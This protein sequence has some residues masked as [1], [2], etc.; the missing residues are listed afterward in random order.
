MIAAFVY[1]VNLSAVPRMFTVEMSQEFYY[2][3]YIPIN[4]TNIPLE[5]CTQAH[6]NFEGS[7]SKIGQ[8]VPLSHALCPPIGQQA[9]VKGKLTSDIYAHVAIRVNR[10]NSTT[11]PSCMNDS[12]FAA[13]EVSVGR[14]VMVTAFV[15]S[16]INPSS[17]DY[18]DYYL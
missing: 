1:G 18:R 15:N 14:F 11:D 5:P 9:I 3:G 17:S 12:V 4:S 6:F 10:C 7:V 13:V 2:S 8:K 16:N